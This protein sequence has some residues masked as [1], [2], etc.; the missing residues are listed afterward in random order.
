MMPKLSTLLLI[1]AIFMGLPLTASAG[2]VSLAWNANTQSDLAGYLVNYGTSSGVYSTQVNVGNVTTYTV[3][4][5]PPGPTI[6][7]SRLTAQQER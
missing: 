2:N 7:Q 6:S 5:S 3:R 4:T 1:A